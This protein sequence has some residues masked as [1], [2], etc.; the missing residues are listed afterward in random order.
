MSF[1]TGAADTSSCFFV[2]PDCGQQYPVSRPDH[3]CDAQGQRLAAELLDLVIDPLYS[4]ETGSIESGIGLL[5]LYRIAYRVRSRMNGLGK[6]KDRAEMARRVCEL[7]R[8]FH[9]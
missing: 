4:D 3:A 2:C 1:P 8:E 6:Y 7:A 9:K 5:W